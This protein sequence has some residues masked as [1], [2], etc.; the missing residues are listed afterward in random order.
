MDLIKDYVEKNSQR[1]IWFT[2]LGMRRY[3]SALQY[4]GAVVGNSSSGIAEVPSFH[5]PTL[6]IGDRQKG[7]IAAT[8]VINCLPVKD[9]IKEKLATITKPDYIESLRDVVNPY[10]KSN[11]AQE[12][13]RIIKE[14]SHISATKKFYNISI[15]I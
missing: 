14:R 6:N 5:I 3:L 13:T 11:T 15:N 7:R 2:S 8:S 9:D 12:I 1:A 4:I 10:D